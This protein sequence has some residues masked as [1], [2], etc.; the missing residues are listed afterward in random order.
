NHLGQYG[1]EFT[2]LYT[3]TNLPM[4]YFEDFLNDMDYYDEYMDILRNAFNPVTVPN[5]MCRSQ[6][7][8]GYDGQLYD[9][10]FHQ[11]ANL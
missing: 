8:V 1:I 2:N 7:S 11:M 10:D 3:I 9:C 4:G 5:L 6:L